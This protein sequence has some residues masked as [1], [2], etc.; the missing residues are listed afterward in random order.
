MLET[1]P[2]NNQYNH[3]FFLKSK[4]QFIL[5]NIN[6]TQQ[7]LHMHNS[8]SERGWVFPCLPSSHTQFT[9]LQFSRRN[10]LSKQHGGGVRRNNKMR[11]EKCY[12]CSSTVYPG[13]GIQFVRNDCKVSCRFFPFKTFQSLFTAHVA[14][15][16][17][18]GSTCFR[19][20]TVFDSVYL[21]RFVV[22]FLFTQRNTSM[23]IYNL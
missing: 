12:F 22:N 5:L 8:D 15:W 3:F 10:F 19:Q 1:V 16:S 4:P 21:W 2:F 9:Q 17:F 7:W 23:E 14:R 18:F 11:L 6:S 13:H 20:G